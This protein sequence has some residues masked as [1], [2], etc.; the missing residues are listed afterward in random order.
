[1]KYG[2]IHITLLRCIQYVMYILSMYIV[3]GSRL[4]I[5]CLF[6]LSYMYSYKIV[7]QIYLKWLVSTLHVIRPVRHICI[8]HNTIISNKSYIHNI[9]IYWII[10]S[11]FANLHKSI[12]FTMLKVWHFVRFCYISWH[13]QSLAH[14]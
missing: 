13:F 8:L 10:I 4:H 9:M 3:I 5:I 6:Y 12:I 2:F 7:S 11:C 14:I 1:M